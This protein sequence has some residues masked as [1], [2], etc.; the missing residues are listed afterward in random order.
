ML[1]PTI[2]PTNESTVVYIHLLHIYSGVVCEWVFA[3]AHDI[4]KQVLPAKQ[5]EIPLRLVGEQKCNGQ[6][7]NSTPSEPNDKPEELLQREKLD[8]DE[9]IHTHN[10][11]ESQLAELSED[12]MWD[13]VISCN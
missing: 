8:A 12:L 6:D 1:L 7:N 2:L 5:E 10:D 9:Q 4:Q 13:F 3:V 11:N